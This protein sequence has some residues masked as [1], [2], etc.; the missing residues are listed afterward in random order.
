MSWSFTVDRAQK[1]K[2]YRDTKIGP[3]WRDAL[4]LFD[5][6]CSQQGRHIYKLIRNWMPLWKG[7]EKPA[8]MCVLGKVNRE[9]II[10]MPTNHHHHQNLWHHWA[11]IK[12]NVKCAD[13]W[14]EKLGY[15]KL[16]IFRIKRRSC[17]LTGS[18]EMF[19][20]KVCDLR[21]EKNKGNI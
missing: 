8:D 12:H 21:K 2:V 19:Q 14:N 15:E 16:R 7:E 18:S 6:T 20:I 4:E 17:V 1:A 11:F 3:S 9:A 13:K 5:S 10:K